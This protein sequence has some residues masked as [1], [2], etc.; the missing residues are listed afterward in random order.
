MRPLRSEGCSESA[1][2]PF[3]ATSRISRTSSTCGGGRHWSDTRS[4]TV[5]PAPRL[6]LI[7][8]PTRAIAD[9]AGR[10]GAVGAPSGSGVGTRYGAPAR[11]QN[12]H[13]GPPDLWHDAPGTAATMEEDKHMQRPIGVT[14]LAIGAGVAGLYQIWLALVYLGIFNFTVVGKPVSFPD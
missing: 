14:L 9:R 11:H 8:R 12:Q 4:S 7:R 13:S 1:S 5:S 3:G 2:T 6:P 10:R